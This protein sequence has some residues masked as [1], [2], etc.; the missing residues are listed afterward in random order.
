MFSCGENTQN[1]NNSDFIS[2]DSSSF[3][4]D[5]LPINLQIE[6][7]IYN[8]ALSHSKIDSITKDVEILLE[9]N[10]LIKYFYPNMHYCGGAI[11]GY[12][13][14]E[15]LKYTESNFN[16]EFVSTFKKIYFHEGRII[17]ILFKRCKVVSGKQEQ[18]KNF[19][20]LDYNLI[21]GGGSKGDFL[22]ITM[23]NK[24]EFQNL[25]RGELSTSEFDSVFLESEI[26]CAHSMKTTLEK[27]FEIKKHQ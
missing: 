18:E 21:N 13:H 5:T 1:Q 24:I 16:S 9:N 27:E 8:D 22:I 12:F 26:N 15:E 23:G 6:D 3:N 19:Q 2:V 10:K 25:L 11:Y 14:D 7:L 4:S 20:D 17:R